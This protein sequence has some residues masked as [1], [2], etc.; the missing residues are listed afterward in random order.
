MLDLGKSVVD[1]NY[2]ARE[3]SALTAVSVTPDFKR[4]AELTTELRNHAQAI[5]MWAFE[6]LEKK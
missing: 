6:E 2:I 1:I 3:L 5:R 4:I